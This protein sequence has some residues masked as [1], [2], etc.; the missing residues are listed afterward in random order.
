MTSLSTSIAVTLFVELPDHH[1]IL[2]YPSVHGYNKCSCLV[3]G[4]ATYLWKLSIK[5]ISGELRQ[6]TCCERFRH[7][8]HCGK[9]R[10]TSKWESLSKVLLQTYNPFQLSKKAENPTISQCG[11]CT[12]VVW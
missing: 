8:Y 12:I 1:S 5:S 2:R 11:H 3:V 10:I 6:W 7:H 9:R 4:I